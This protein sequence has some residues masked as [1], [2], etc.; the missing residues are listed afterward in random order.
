MEG[1]KFI[2]AFSY[3]TD[4][5]RVTRNHILYIRIAEIL[6]R[7]D[8]YIVGQRDDVTSYKDVF[9]ATMS[10][11]MNTF[12]GN[13]DTL[14]S[15]VTNTAAKVPI[16]SKTTSLD[17]VLEIKGNGESI[18]LKDI[19]TEGNRLD[20]GLR[21]NPSK[22][23]ADVKSSEY[24]WS[25][26]VE[27]LRQLDLETMGVTYED[28]TYVISATMV[29]DLLDFYAKEEIA[30]T[31]LGKLD[32]DYYTKYYKTIVNKLR[33]HFKMS[34]EEVQDK[35]STW[36]ALYLQNKEM[37]KKQFHYL[38][39]SKVVIYNN[40]VP[41][42]VSSHFNV[43]EGLISRVEGSK[44]STQI[45]KFRYD[46]VLD[47]VFDE[48]F[49][50]DGSKLVLTIGKHT[51]FNVFGGIFTEERNLIGFV[52]ENLKEYIVNAITC[53]YIAE[54]NDYLYLSIQSKQQTII[55]P[56]YYFG[57]MFTITLDSCG[58]FCSLE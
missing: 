27:S 17:K 58:D 4:L 7:F 24:L 53:G 49:K 14:E 52:K 54:S 43:K 1:S 44:G 31:A 45:Y 22:L 10:T 12:N 50:E 8:K 30:L 40:S 35:L 51:Y 21:V 37:F 42:K 11:V 3:I 2:N 25:D 48:Y 29:L 34:R 39:N 26:W 33:D 41:M 13:W 15:H 19:I 47:L 32:K 20:T 28:I 23:L 5:E 9:D 56:M 55:I 36:G 46:E 16:K 38:L 57:I 18:R 6:E